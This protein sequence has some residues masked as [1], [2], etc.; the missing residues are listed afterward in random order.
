MCA[1]GCSCVLSPN[2]AD[3]YV[4]PSVTRLST[5]TFYA[6]GVLKIKEKTLFYLA[7]PNFGL[8]ALCAMSQLAVIS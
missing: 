5:L 4:I 2:S 1:F 7:R 3:F 6:P 8:R